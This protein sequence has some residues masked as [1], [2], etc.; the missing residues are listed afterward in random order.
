V[1][2][3]IGELAP[4]ALVP[5]P[6]AQGLDTVG[7]RVQRLLQPGFDVCQLIPATCHFGK[8]EIRAHLS[9]VELGGVAEPLLG[10]R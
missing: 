7:V 9:R 1:L 2:F 10:G 8:T 5:A 4:I 3:R 6:D